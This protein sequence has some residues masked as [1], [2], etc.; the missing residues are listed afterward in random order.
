MRIGG[1]S[2]LVLAALSG[3]VPP[4]VVHYTSFQDREFSQRHQPATLQEKSAAE[5]LNG[6]YLLIGYLDLRRNLRTCYE[7]G[8]CVNHS[9][10]LPSR[11]ELLAEAALH[12][13]DVLTL[14]EERTLIERHDKS[15]CASY[16]TTTTMVNNVP[17]VIT[18]CASNRTVAGNME[19]RVSRALIWR[20]DPDAARSD[21]NA[22]AIESAMRTLEAAYRA[23]ESKVVAGTASKGSNPAATKTGGEVQ[24]AL[25]PLS[26]QVYRAIDQNDAPSLYRLARDGQ[27]QAWRDE[28]GRTALMLALFSDRVDAA[29]T[30]L[31][32]DSGVGRR[33]DLGLDALH[34]AA[35]WG[36]LAM[37]QALVKAGHDV[38][39]KTKD[40]ANLLFYAAFNRRIEVFDWLYAQ[41]LDPHMVTT[42]GETLLIAAGS[43]GNQAVIQRL[44][45]LGLD[46]NAT[47][48]SGQSAVMFA[49]RSGQ[50]AAMDALLKARPQLKA[51]DRHGNTVLHYAAI[52]GQ[53]DI[54]QMLLVRDLNVNAEDNDGRSPILDAIFAEKWDAMR[55]LAEHGAR[56]TTSKFSAEDIA[57]YLISKNQPQGLRAYVETFA[58]LNELVRRDPDWLQYA[59]QVSGPETIK[60]MVGL[61]ARVD[62]PATDGRTALITAAAAGNPETV[63]A[64]LE[65]KANATLRDRNDQTA[66]KIA[67]LNAHAKVV[68]TLREFNVNE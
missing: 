37:V 27:L 50:G 13:G 66:L 33:D 42:D 2:W 64:L 22:R 61:G 46:V 40:K 48:H 4:R 28:K 20:Y 47:T 54:L 57:T 23:D 49:A 9:D 29:R 38:H 56:L 15:V 60:Y 14:L 32:I 10:T 35:G 39:G 25:D 67:T 24:R 6:G 31:A 65:L 52:G 51:T 59:A 45:A 3:C 17:Q 11:E 58:P 30:L 5:L 1:A 41:K 21:A 7:N 43:A 26:A 34:Y 44:L 68:E 55:Y 8:Q 36:D 18:S 63:R 62:R 53:R 12:G 16:H 19:A